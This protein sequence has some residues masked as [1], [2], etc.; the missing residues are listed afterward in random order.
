MVFFYIKLGVAPQVF[1]LTIASATQV[2]SVV[3]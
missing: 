3:I 1:A 2:F